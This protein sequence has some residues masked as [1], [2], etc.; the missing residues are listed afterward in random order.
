MGWG[1]VECGVRKVVLW[2]RGRITGGQARPNL[3]LAC[4]IAISRPYQAARGRDLHAREVSQALPE[5]A[6][7]PMAH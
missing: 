7:V 2:S 6:P 3:A 4:S 1:R 5:A